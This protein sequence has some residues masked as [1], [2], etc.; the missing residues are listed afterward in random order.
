M[1]SSFKALDDMGEDYK[2]SFCVIIPTYNN[3]K[4]LERVITK[5]LSFTNDIIIVNDG[6][7]DDSV[8]ILEKFP[9]LTQIHFHKNKGKGEAL[10]AGF[11]QAILDD[12]QYAIT[13][14]SDGQHYPEDIPIFLEAIA[15][16]PNSLLIGSRNMTHETVPKNSSFGN[17]FSNFWFWFETG[18]RL[19]D[20]QSGFRLYP[21]KAIKSI[22]LITTKFEFEIEIIVRLAW[23]GTHIENVPI[24]VL[25][26]ANER[27]SHF[28]PIK[29]FVRISLLNTWLVI[30]AILYIKPRD[31][32][33][34]VQRKGVRKFF[35]EHVIVSSD[36]PLKKSL[37]VALGVFIGIAP[38]WGVQTVLVLFLALILKLNKAIAFAFSNIS[39]P[40]MIPVIIYGSIKVGEFILNSKSSFNLSNIK[41][42]K[43][44]LILLKEYIVGSFALALMSA[45]LLGLI[46]FVYL[47]I[48]QKSE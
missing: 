45:I 47:T 26:D 28:R 32:F 12:F 40:P 14:D 13:I 34:K 22:Q 48:N 20:T 6:C 4:T 15:E 44:T 42:N 27:V 10:K 9:Q 24:R 2:F 17:K 3:Q 11:S 5:T 8:K 38:F 29:D 33:K 25:Y 30:V 1:N 43:D 16:N 31:L 19:S 35:L 46:S 39:I 21:L 41:F 36:P 18:I 23:R 37:S 7:T